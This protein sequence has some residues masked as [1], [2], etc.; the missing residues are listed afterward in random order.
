VAK[1]H[2]NRLGDLESMFGRLE[3]L[4]LANSGADEFEEVFKLIVAKLWDES[5]SNAPRFHVYDDDSEAFSAVTSLL[6]EA[7]KAW[8]GIVEPFA[9]PKLTPE[10]LQVCVAALSRHK[11]LDESLQVMDSFFEF[12]VARTAKGAKGQYFTPRHVVEFCVRMLQPKANE[13]VLDP[14]CG[15]GG[16][17]V[18]VLNYVR[19][20]EALSP[21][22]TT[23]YSRRKL[24]GFDIDARAIRV[25]KALMVMAG[26]GGS[27]IMRLNSLVKPGGIQSVF[28]G[29]ETDESVMTVEDVCRTRLRRHR[30]FDVILTNPPFAGEVRERRILDSY[31]VAEGKPRVER[32]ILFLERCLELLRPGGRLAIILPHNKFAA[33][34]YANTRH[35]LLRKARILGVVGLGRNTFLPHTHQKAS[36]LFAQRRSEPMDGRDEKIFFAVSERDGKNSKGQLC[37]L[38]SKDR[39]DSLWRSVDHDLSDLVGAFQ[40]FCE[41]ERISLGNN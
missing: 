4:V 21:A 31:S 8:P 30:G 34:S 24:W 14:A 22:K 37:F 18:H 33:E 35:W 25:A 41:A 32:D 5:K 39:G 11:I 15:S 26:D 29:L 10:H 2:G 23:E 40:Q 1:R 27:N 36:I 16:F 6:R 20:Q 12:M 38:N 19:E 17:L 7:E 3:E 13:M 28:S 9:L